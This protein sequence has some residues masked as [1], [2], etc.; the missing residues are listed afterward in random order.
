[1]VSRKKAGITIRTDSIA[2]KR[3]RRGIPLLSLNFSSGKKRYFNMRD[4]IFFFLSEGNGTLTP[5]IP[6][7]V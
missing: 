4:G 7:R 6:A 3:E 2:I 5:S 1:M